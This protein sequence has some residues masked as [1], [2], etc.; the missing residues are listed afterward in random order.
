MARRHPSRCAPRRFGKN[1]VSRVR[2]LENRKSFTKK[3]L[4]GF[5][6]LY[7][8]FNIVQTTL[9]LNDHVLKK[10]LQHHRRHFNVLV[11]RHSASFNVQQRSYARITDNVECPGSFGQ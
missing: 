2:L 5:I 4:S 10:D 3:H 6:F 11:L 7:V 8:A 1:D 9:A